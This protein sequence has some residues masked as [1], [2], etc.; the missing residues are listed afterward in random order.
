MITDRVSI[1]IGDK[2]SHYSLIDKAVRIIKDTYNG[3]FNVYDLT[4]LDSFS[5]EEKAYLKKI[6]SH[7]FT[8]VDAWEHCFYFQEGVW[9][10]E[11]S[12]YNHEKAI[13]DILILLNTS[14]TSI[15]EKVYTNDYRL[16]ES[17]I[18][19]DNQLWDDDVEGVH[20][21]NRIYEV[22]FDQIE[23]ISRNLKSRVGDYCEFSFEF[24]KTFKE[25]FRDYCTKRIHEIIREGKL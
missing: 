20:I 19:G 8:S 3:E 14:T 5:V 23:F 4:S 18:R 12:D 6:F 16:I 1:I 22:D 11:E 21:E 13:R 24:V 25:S 2:K 7:K 9:K 17:L 10:Y 15:G